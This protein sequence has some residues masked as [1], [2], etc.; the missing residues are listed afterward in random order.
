[1]R[2]GYGA[3]FLARL[4]EPLGFD[5]VWSTEHHVTGYQMCPDV[6]QFPHR[7]RSLGILLIPQRPWQDIRGELD[8]YRALFREHHGEEAPPPVG[9]AWIFCDDDE[10]R[11]H[12]EAA[13][14]ESSAT[15]TCPSTWRSGT[16]AALRVP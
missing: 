14:S 4:A 9:V 8:E 16:C 6:L 13:R 12:D 10:A 15:P 2:L 5:S 1:M 3:A 11:A 7:G